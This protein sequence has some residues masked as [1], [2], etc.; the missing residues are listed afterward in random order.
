MKKP[1]KGKFLR[2]YTDIPALLH[3]LKTKSIAFLNP[4]TWDD[5]ND[6]FYIEAYRKRK[7]LTAVLALCFTQK[8][9]T[10]HHWKVF[11]GN[12]SGV[13]IV[14]KKEQLLLL[15][16]GIKQLDIVRNQGIIKHGPVV[17]KSVRAMRKQPPE[18]TM[19]PFLKR[20]V[21]KDDAEYRMIFETKDEGLEYKDFSMKLDCIEKIT[22]SPWMPETLR[23]SVEE[24]IKSIPGCN[25][26]KV[27]KSK[28]IDYKQWKDCV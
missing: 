27:H 18:Q 17:Y 24:T 26:I 28:L 16:D 1:A 15:V 23:K 25:D 19:Y 7:G 13:C 6:S 10:Y 14:F 4:E 12:G 11:A 5:R 2:R 21:F 9:E 8:R 20:I 3:L 22:L